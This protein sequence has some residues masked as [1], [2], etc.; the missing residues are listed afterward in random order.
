M[1]VEEA[2]GR[3]DLAKRPADQGKRSDAFQRTPLASIRCTRSICRDIVAAWP[4]AAPAVSTSSKVAAI[5][6]NFVTIE[7]DLKQRNK[8]SSKTWRGEQS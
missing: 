6:L 8:A 4:H 1:A 2:P 5:W 3:A 7:W